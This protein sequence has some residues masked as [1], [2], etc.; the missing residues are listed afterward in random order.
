M[1]AAFGC[2]S[3]QS[4]GTGGAG[5]V[6]TAGGA[7][8][9]GGGQSAGSSMGSGGAMSAGGAGSVDG[10]ADGSGAQNPACATATAHGFFRDCSLCGA[11]CDTIDDGSGSYKACGCTSGCPCGLHCG[12]YQIAPGV[13]VSDIC[14]R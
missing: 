5:G 6:G 1:V 3:E 14:V 9:M 2:S 7:G 11:D 12:S 4:G 13:T 8:S 10:G